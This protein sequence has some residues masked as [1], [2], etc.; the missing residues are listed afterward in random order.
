[1]TDTQKRIKALKKQLPSVK[2]KVVAMATSL[3]LAVVMLTSVS[4]AW[5]TMS[6]AP[7]VSSI[8]TQISSNGNL[9]VALAYADKD[10][11]LVVPN[12]SGVGDSAAVQGHVPANLT[13][14][15]LLNLSGN[16]G[17]ENLV[18]RPAIL[19]EGSK[20]LLNS[21]YYGEDGRY[22]AEN[23]DFSYTYWTET[24]NGWAFTVSDTP[25]Y[26]VRA[27]S[28][29]TYPDGKGV[30]ATKLDEAHGVFNSVCTRYAWIVRNSKAN[31]ENRYLTV[32]QDLI[33]VYA[34]ATLNSEDADCSAYIDAL[35]DMM[36]DLHYNVIAKYGEVLVM[37]ANAQQSM[38]GDAYTPY[39]LETL[40]A[41]KNTNNLKVQIPGKENEKINLAGSYSVFYNMYVTTRNDLAELTRHKE[42]KAA[43]PVMWSEIDQIVDHLIDI[44]END[45]DPVTGRDRTSV[46]LN[47]ETIT[48]LKT[49]MKQYLNPIDF[50][51][52]SKMLNEFKNADALV[53]GGFL[54]DIELITQTHMSA[55]IATKVSVKGIPADVK[56]NVHTDLRGTTYTRL[57]N[58]DVANT[59][60]VADKDDL[61]YKGA[62]VAGDTYG[63][64]IDLWVRTNAA[65]A[66]LMLDGMLKTETQESLRKLIITGESESR[67]VFIYKYTVNEK[68]T[69]GEGENQ[70]TTT[71]P[72]TYEVELY[73]IPSDLNGNKQFD[74]YTDYKVTIN[75][76]EVTVPV[77]EG[78]LYNIKTGQEAKLIDSNGNELGNLTHEHIG[79]GK[80]VVAAIDSKQ[81]VVGFE[82]SNRVDDDYNNP[83]IGAGNIPGVSATQG[84]G[85][86]YIF[87]ASTAEEYDSAKELL[88]HMKVA[89]VDRNGTVLAKAFMDVAH[90][91]QDNGRYVVPLVLESSTSENDNGDL[92]ITMLRQNEAT[93]ISAVVYLDGTNLENSM[94]MEKGS[95]KGSL[96]LQFTTDL[97]PET[98]PLLP[99]DDE[100]LAAKR[101]AL[102]AA[103]SNNHFEY[104]GSSKTAT[105]TAS[106]TGLEP[107]KVQ[108][109]FVRMFNATQGTQMKFTDLKFTEGQGWVGEPKF[110]LP[111]KYVLN[112][113]WIDG[114][115]Y[116]LPE[117]QRI[118]VTVEGLQIGNISFCS[119]VEG[120]DLELTT[121]SYTTRSISVSIQAEES[122]QPKKMVARFE[123]IGDVD[124]KIVTAN[125]DYDG[126]KNTWNGIV[127]FTQSG[128]YVL[129]QLIM[130]GAPTDVTERGY[131]FSAYLGLKTNIYIASVTPG[132]GLEYEFTGKQEFRVLAEILTDDGSP[133]LNLQDVKLYYA[134]RG[135]SDRDL[136]LNATLTWNGEYYEC[137]FPVLKPGVYEFGD[138]NLGG[139]NV[140][141]SANM[142]PVIKGY[143]K[144]LPVYMHG[145]LTKDDRTDGVGASIVLSSSSSSVVKYVVTLKS[146]SGANMTAVFKDPAG[147]TVLVGHTGYKEN[148]DGTFTFTFVIPKTTG[149]DN[150]HGE[151]VLQE[152]RATGVYAPDGTYYG[153]SDDPNVKPHYTV[154]SEGKEFAILDTVTATINTNDG[155][156]LGSAES[157][158]AFLT[159]Q[160]VAK[161][162]PVNIMTG[163]NENNLVDLNKYGMYIKRAEVIFNHK[164]ATSSTY[165]GYTFSGTKTVGS[166]ELAY[167]STAKQWYLPENMVSVYLAGEYTYT[168]NV[169]IDAID[170]TAGAFTDVTYSKSDDK[171]ILKVYSTKPSV[172]ISDI[173][174]DGN[175]A[176]S[177]DKIK[178]G[179]L[180]DTSTYETVDSG[181]IK[182]YYYTGHTHADHIGAAQAQAN[183]WISRIES[184]N[185]TA[186]LYFKC[187]HTDAATYEAGKTNGA[188]NATFQGH[189]YSYENGTGVPAA[190]LTLTGVGNGFTS[191]LEFEKQ[192]GGDVIMITQYTHDGGNKTTYWG[193]YA[194]YG[195]SSFE[196][197]NGATTCM[198]FVG[199][200]DNGQGSNNSDTKK[201][202]ETIVGKLLKITDSQ[203]TVYTVD[204]ADITIHNPY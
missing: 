128:N 118:T 174:L 41:A 2:G 76:E 129:T 18:L 101:V 153:K 154:W 73:Q 138:M 21:I 124:K 142:A 185:R 139:T 155:A 184:G 31:D 45:K 166:F 11:N 12:S 179:H 10:G 48:E 135:V 114:V 64:V 93:F 56:A 92:G 140:I 136:G 107:K 130:D 53:R 69:T 33:G 82:G 149:K 71:V 119:D 87:Y 51:G 145:N 116:D 60:A 42:N 90:I 196:W 193:D 35:C 96:N 29:V 19:A 188:G 199:V 103:I 26:G 22:E 63:M 146:A 200:M 20:N 125:L 83:Q 148:D 202:A 27:I 61:E 172:Y 157:S 204:I 175:G 110:T 40:V 46:L 13:W 178:D 133:L 79:E 78:K 173:T 147:E 120:E 38:Y 54:R 113:L 134:K 189:T 28:T 169:V 17:I 104:D 150:S 158:A 122:L 7:E 36:E 177:V 52:I 1:M 201:V 68:V 132:V 72:M 70:T 59:E 151:W 194:T 23:V 181:C 109:A 176:Y 159:T 102:T 198:R 65:D 182:D 80:A 143:T 32:I 50:S 81:I 161:R 43:D 195:T 85:S 95:I 4:F 44:T 190:T 67:Q 3:L 34:T 156:T 8:R 14:G 180:A 98:N 197:K 191:V 137:L 111:G 58:L 47:G 77:F 187:N 97:D 106:V 86:C 16:Y 55:D 30:M 74:Q 168:V 91:Q 112:T 131:T 108:A 186:Y 25:K 144:E 162:I 160:T 105:L 62:M 121:D 75:G 152:I 57:Y 165:G 15:N 99:K 183:N 171:V 123:T 49:R 39:T 66:L 100:D 5:Y 24:Q 164:N 203:G 167:D 84:S 170:E 115:E 94:V 117:D 163:A 192:G 6:R 127:R 9:E 88:N 89:F 126:D 37:L 141:R